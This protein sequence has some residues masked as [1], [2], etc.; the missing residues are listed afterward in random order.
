[1][2]TWT[3]FLVLV[4]G[5]RAET[6]PAPFSYILNMHIISSAAL[7]CTQVSDVWPPLESCARPGSETGAPLH[8]GLGGA[9]PSRAPWGCIG[10]F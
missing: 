10:V 4:C 7:L 1:M 8:L 6:L 5:A 9:E 3:H 2:L